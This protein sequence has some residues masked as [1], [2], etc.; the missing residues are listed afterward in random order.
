M[1]TEPTSPAPDFLALHRPGDPLLL[2]NAWDLG[3]ARVLE[4]LGFAAVATTSSG[5]AATLGR[6]DGAVT[7]DEALDHAAAM[8]VAVGV[9]VSADLENGFADA[10]DDVAR[11]VAAVRDAGL[12]G[13]SVE[14]FTGDAARPIYDLGLAVERVAAA[15]E[16]SGDL[17]LTA[18][19]ENHL[20]GHDDLADTIARL[21]AYQ[22]AGADVLF[23]PGLRTVADVATVCRELDR[24]V[25]V[26]LVAGGPTPAELADAGAA[27]L[28]VGGAL[29]WTA[30]DALVSAARGLLAGDSGFLERSAAVRDVRDAALRPASG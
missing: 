15:A 11:T 17:V 18:R 9:P 2:P 3:S 6:P 12:A 13:C 14:D 19:C 5:F 20:H 10:P 26:L 27:R 7:R 1:S 23:A 4:T 22:E 25:N 30:L 29:A 28:S 8:A 16:T 21:Q 24:P